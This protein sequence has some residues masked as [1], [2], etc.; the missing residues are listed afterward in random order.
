[1]SNTRLTLTMTGTPLLV[2]VALTTLPRLSIAIRPVETSVVV[3][4]VKTGAVLV[5]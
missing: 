3:R 4:P 1:M 2:P 5:K